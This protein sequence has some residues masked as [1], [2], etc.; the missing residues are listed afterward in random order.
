MGKKSHHPNY[1]VDFILF[2][3]LKLYPHR[4]WSESIQEIYMQVFNIKNKSANQSFFRAQN[5]NYKRSGKFAPT[6]C[7][8]QYKARECR[9]YLAIV[10]VLLQE[11]KGIRLIECK[12][13]DM[14]GNIA[15]TND[16]W[17]RLVFTKVDISN[18]DIPRSLYVFKF[19]KN[20]T[21][22]KKSSHSVSYDSGKPFSFINTT[23]FTLS[24]LRFN[25]QFSFSE[26][27]L[28]PNKIGKS[29]EKFRSLI[30]GLQIVHI[31]ILHFMVNPIGIQYVILIQ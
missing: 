23:N 14:W 18:L 3:G 28:V 13:A 11:K 7:P 9:F 27:F 4:C 22:Y 24:S 20:S 25:T 26:L 31:Y 16:F 19:F 15:Q 30:L 21:F 12:L 17:A 2:R 5:R 1:W 6:M 8:T 10:T 29:V